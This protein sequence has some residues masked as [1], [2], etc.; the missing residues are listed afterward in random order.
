[1]QKKSPDKGLFF[2]ISE[3][4][5]RQTIRGGG[6]PRLPEGFE[7]GFNVLFNNFRYRIKLVGDC[8]LLGI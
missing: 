6:C 5:A 1:M 3:P 2:N 7:G 4:I 8:I